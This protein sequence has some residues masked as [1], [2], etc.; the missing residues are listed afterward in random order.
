MAAAL[1]GEAAIR[2]G[3]VRLVRQ[4]YEVTLLYPRFISA[5]EFLR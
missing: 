4:P 5:V 2:A 1:A 3:G